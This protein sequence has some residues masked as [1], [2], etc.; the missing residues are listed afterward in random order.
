MSRLIRDADT[1]LIKKLR[2][3]NARASYTYVLAPR[4]EG[5][6]QEGKYG[7]EFIITDEETKALIKE[8]TK[9][10][11]QQAIKG[12][13]GKVP[14]NL[15]LPYRNGD[16]E[17]ESEAGALILKTGSPKFQPAILIRDEKTGRA[18]HITE[19]DKD[20]IYSGMYADADV[21]FKEWAVGGKFGVT[22]YLNAICKVA[23]GEPFV[24]VSSIED[25]FSLD[26]GFDDDDSFDSSYKG[27]ENDTSILSLDDLLDA[28][29]VDNKQAPKKEVNSTSEK[30]AAP[31]LTIDDLL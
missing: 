30:T 1:G 6:L 12:A 15:V 31:Q 18:R 27:G 13:W 29:P 17:K 19:E 3:T 28:E 25:S 5:S 8:Y 2:I 20:D 26:L 24:P 9:E 10:V 4:P 23:E 21:T 14:N 11:A 7:S 22:A 16:E